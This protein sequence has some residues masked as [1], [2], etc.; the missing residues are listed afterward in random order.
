MSN[1]VATPHRGGFVREAE[2]DIARFVVENVMRYLR[3]EEPE[4]LVDLE[5]GY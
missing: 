2:I 4:G 3:G 5:R 1:V